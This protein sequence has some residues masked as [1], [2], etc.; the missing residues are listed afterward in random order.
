MA[1]HKTRLSLYYPVG[2]LVPS[3][4][5]LLLAPELTLKLL[6]SNGDYGTILP[7]FAGVLVLGLGILVLQIVRQRIEALYTTLVWIRVYFCACW[8]GLFLASRDPMFLGL[9]VTVGFGV[10]L[11]TLGLVADRQ[12]ARPALT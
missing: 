4:L 11:T 10:C 5:G 1:S 2:Y 8:L 9:L 12:P 3:G 6:F 7:R